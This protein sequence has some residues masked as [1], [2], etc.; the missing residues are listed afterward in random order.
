MLSVDDL[1]SVL[2][3]DLKISIID[4]TMPQVCGFSILINQK[5]IQITVEPNT[6]IIWLKTYLILSCSHS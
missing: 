4:L 6:E 2:L 1:S 3:N 5:Y